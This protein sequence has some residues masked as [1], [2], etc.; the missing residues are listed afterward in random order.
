[1]PFR[2]IDFLLWYTIGKYTTNNDV[3]TN[4]VRYIYNLHYKLAI[5]LILS[6][7]LLVFYLLSSSNVYCF[8]CFHVDR[9]TRLYVDADQKIIICLDCCECIGNIL[10]SKSY[11][12]IL[13]VR[14]SVF[15]LI[16]APF[17]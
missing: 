4:T 16:W 11:S 14:L 15:Y 7:H 12:C 5:T 10:T 2:F 17:W 1:M 9:Y 3:A 8:H 6:I 13:C